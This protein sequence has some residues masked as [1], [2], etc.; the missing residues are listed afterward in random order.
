MKERT[1]EAK[2]HIRHTIV[3][4]KLGNIENVAPQA[5]NNAW[6]PTAAV[7][8]EVSWKHMQETYFKST[9]VS[10]AVNE[11]DGC[12]AFITEQKPRKK[13]IKVWDP[14]GRAP[15]TYKDYKDPGLGIIKPGNRK[16]R[17]WTRNPKALI[18]T[19]LGGLIAKDAIPKL[20][21]E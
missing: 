8:P 1:I 3:M 15:G 11:V 18:K 10:R 14:T 9:T 16:F 20:I 12:T 6:Y 17:V 13:K 21:K 5:Q 19:K 7:K 2:E 4:I